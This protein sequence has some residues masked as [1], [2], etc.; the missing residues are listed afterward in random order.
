MQNMSMVRTGRAKEATLIRLIGLLVDPV[1]LRFLIS[2][3]F[4]MCLINGFT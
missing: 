4:C 3:L 1:N 2:V